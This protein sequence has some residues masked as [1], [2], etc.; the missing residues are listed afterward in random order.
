M[1]FLV[2]FEDGILWCKSCG[3]V[4]TKT[5]AI[6]FHYRIAVTMVVL[7]KNPVGHHKLLGG[8]QKKHWY[9]L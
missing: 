9:K 1:G 7:K 3:I 6:R 4:K 8:N 5:K 2:H